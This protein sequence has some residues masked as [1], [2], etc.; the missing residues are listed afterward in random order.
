MYEC[1]YVLHGGRQADSSETVRRRVLG[2]GVARIVDKRNWGHVRV[3]ER[4]VEEVEM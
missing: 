1:E 3:N 2:Q 4:Q